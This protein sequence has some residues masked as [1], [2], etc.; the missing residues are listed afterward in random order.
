MCGRRWKKPAHL[1]ENRVMSDW[2]AEEDDIILER[3]LPCEREAQVAG[4][5]DRL[6]GLL[7][8]GERARGLGVVN[9]ELVRRRAWGLITRYNGTLYR[10]PQGHRVRRGNAAPTLFEQELLLQALHSRS[11]GAVHGADEV[12]YFAEVLQRPVAWVDK[13]LKELDPRRLIK[14]FFNGPA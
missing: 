12:R 14:G 10:G 9:G 2:T 7:G 4:E 1:K 13:T 6:A 11:V 5:C 3:L 8:R